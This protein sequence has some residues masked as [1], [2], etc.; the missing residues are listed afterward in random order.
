MDEIIT[1]AQLKE[2]AERNQQ[3]TYLSNKLAQALNDLEISQSNL[4]EFAL[5]NSALPLESFAA[6]S[7]GLDAFREQLNRTSE[8][9]DAV[10]ALL[11]ILQNETLDEKNYISLRQ[12]FPIVDRVEFRRIL[13]QNEIISSWN[14]PEISTVAAVFDTLTER[15]SRLQSQIDASQI[16]AERSGLT[17]DVYAK[18]LREQKQS[19]ATYAVLIESV[20]AQ[21]MFLGYKSNKAQIYE[22]ASPSINPSEPK[23]TVILVLGAC[24][25]LFLGIAFSLT[26][27]FVHG[28]CNSKSSLINKSQARLTASIRSLLPMRNK[29]LLN[30]NSTLMKKPNS[31]LRDMAVEIHKSDR[32]QVVISSLRA[33]ITSDDVAKALATYMQSDTMKIAILDFSSKR[34]K[35]DVNTSQLSHGQFLIAEN[36]DNI[37]VLKPSGDLPIMELLSKKDFCEIIESLNSTFNIVF[38]CADNSDVFSL[39]RALEGQKLFHITLAK[40]KRTKSATLSHVRSLLSIQGLLYD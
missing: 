2:E 3:L 21:N 37:S 10:A 14:W 25:G 5:K 29:N 6:E 17:L 9:Y 34:K 40:T 12:R 16:D 33:K 11:L 26:L 22:Y 7:L 8:L 18:L 36:F 19:E 1:S 38:L 4:N 27:A 15:R 31:V 35:L 30:I 39:L 13:G 28:A 20:K 23:N 32:T 24:L